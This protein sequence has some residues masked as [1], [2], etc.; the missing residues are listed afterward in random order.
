MLPCVLPS[1]ASSFANGRFTASTHLAVL[2]A[3]G[4]ADDDVT[5]AA[6][7]E[8]QATAES[9]LHK[10]RVTPVTG[11]TE[12]VPTSVTQPTVSHDV[13]VSLTVFHFEY[14]HDRFCC[15]LQLKS[16]MRLR[17]SLLAK[18]VPI[19]QLVWRKFAA[20][21]T[22]VLR[23]KRKKLLTMFWP[24]SAGKFRPYIL[25]PNFHL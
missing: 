14:Y 16:V 21:L 24:R 15:K 5:D 25:K 12:A 4:D 23:H 9:T 18:Y 22:A 6:T 3:L 2:K 8:L 17:A 11:M 1:P 10:P 7:V 20:L 19:L 13:I